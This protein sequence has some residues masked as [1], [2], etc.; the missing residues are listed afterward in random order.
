MLRVIDSLQLAE[1]Y[2]VAKPG[3]WKDGDNVVIS[4]SVKDEE[5]PAKFPKGYQQRK[6]YLRMTPQP[7]K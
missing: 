6:P 5:L 1:E 3:N 4:L 2:S 7:N